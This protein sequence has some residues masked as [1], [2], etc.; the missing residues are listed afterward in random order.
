MST[1]T[2]GGIGNLT[3]NQTVGGNFLWNEQS[4]AIYIAGRASSKDRV[5]DSIRNQEDP[6]EVL[7]AGGR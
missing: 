3:L 2:V 7:I 5:S 6:V 1:V 4:T